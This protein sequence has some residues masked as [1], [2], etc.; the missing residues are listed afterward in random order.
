MKIKYKLLIYLVLILCAIWFFYKD[1][2]MSLLGL[3]NLKAGGTI[4]PNGEMS[5][6][7]KAISTDLLS[8]VEN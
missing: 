4:S 1:Q 7:D 8:Q 5:S 2:I 6:T 3:A